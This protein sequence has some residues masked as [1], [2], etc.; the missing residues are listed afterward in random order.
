MITKWLLKYIQFATSIT[1]RCA[2]ERLLEAGLEEGAERALEVDHVE[3]VG[4][5]DRLAAVGDPA[6]QLIALV[7]DE[8]EDDLA[9]QVAPAMG[10]RRPRLP[11]SR[12][13]VWT[14]RGTRC[15]L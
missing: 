13:T 4:D 7:D 3:A 14:R 1:H 2:D 8:E 11:E 9:Q 10:Q 15:G 12:G 6:H 5:R